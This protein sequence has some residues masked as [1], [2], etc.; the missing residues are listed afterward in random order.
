MAKNGQD[1]S[2]QMVDQFMRLAARTKTPKV[3]Y[4][5]AGQMK[6]IEERREKERLAAAKEKARL[7]QRAQAIKKEQDDYLIWQAKRSAV[8]QAN[9]KK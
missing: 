3:D 8:E 9:K 2:N 1:R 6:E 4:S 5:I 7:A